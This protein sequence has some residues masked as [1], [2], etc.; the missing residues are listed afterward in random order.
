MSMNN[1]K[2]S[3]YLEHH[4]VKGMHWGKR[5]YQ[6]RDGSLTALGR[7][8]R[9]IKGTRKKASDMV[10]DM[11]DAVRKRQAHS[12]AINAQ[13]KKIKNDI[14]AKA[15]KQR[16]K[17]QLAKYKAQQAKKYGYLSPAEVK[18]KKEEEARKA[19]EKKEI[20]AVRDKQLHDRAVA[21]ASGNN[22]NTPSGSNTQQNK[23]QKSAEKDYGPYSSKTL[24][25]KGLGNL[26]NQ[27][28]NAL[29]ERT[30]LENSYAQEAAKQ[31]KDHKYRDKMVNAAID[32]SIDLG[33]KAV[34]AYMYKKMGISQ[35]SNG[36]NKNQNDGGLGKALADGVKNEV[37]NQKKKKQNDK[38]TQELMKGAQELL[39]AVNGSKKDSKGLAYAVSTFA[40]YQFPSGE[41]RE[42]NIQVGKDTVKDLQKFLN[43]SKN[44]S[45]NL[46]SYTTNFNSSL[47]SLG[48][49]DLPPIPK[50][51]K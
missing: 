7:M 29:V 28:L 35:N 50:R 10:G 48:V 12:R 47:G 2:N 15:Q 1:H 39:N 23:K 33:K 40:S 45:Y 13:K 14:K 30:R 25:K 32:T 5:R 21:K 11:G 36:G 42:Q 51:K 6:N 43:D 19:A 9:G 18:A 16:E 34:T 44:S 38:E 8:R 4:G 41:R 24:A 17:E 31:K 22:Q 27:E 46:S 20:Q 49:A 37:A 3:N 26:T